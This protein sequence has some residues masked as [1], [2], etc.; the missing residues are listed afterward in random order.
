MP[1]A[2]A[3]FS[4][5]RFKQGGQVISSKVTWY[6]SH[7]KLNTFQKNNE[8]GLYILLCKH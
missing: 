5:I 1:K 6:R 4:L 7:I 2:K 3:I 8:S